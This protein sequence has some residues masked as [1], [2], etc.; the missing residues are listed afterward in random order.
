MAN[1][2]WVGGTDTWNATAGTKWATTSGGTGGA[3]VPT[4]S[5]DVFFDANS[6]SGTVTLGADG[7]CQDINFTGFTGSFEASSA[8]RINIYGSTILGSGTTYTSY[9]GSLW[10]QGNST[11]TLTTNGKQIGNTTS[12]SLVI[13]KG[14]G[15]LT[16]LDSINSNLI[17]CSFAGGT[18]DLNDFDVTVSF[19]RTTTTNTKTLNMGSGTLTFT[20]F[21]IFSTDNLTLNAETSTI[22]LLVNGPG[23]RSFDGKGLTYHNF[24][25]A[26]TS[27]ADAGSHTIIGSN[28]F[29]SLEVE[30][31]PSIIQFANGTTQ[32]VSNFVADGTSTDGIELKPQSSVSGT[33]WTISKTSGTIEV[34]HC[35]I[36]G[37]EATGGSLWIAK[38]STDDGDNT[39]WHFVEGFLQFPT[40]SYVYTGVTFALKRLYELT[41]NTGNYIYTG[42]NW[43]MKRVYPFLFSTGSY[44]Y[45]GV[46][47]LM[48]YARIFAF[49]TGSYTYSGVNWLM[50]ASRKI[51]FATGHYT[52]T[53]ISWMM[54][55]AY[56][57]A[58]GTGAY[59]YTGITWIMRKAYQI[60]FGVGTYIYKG[61]NWILEGPPWQRENKPPVGDWED[62]IKPFVTDWEDETKPASS[63]WTNDDKPEL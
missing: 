55:L 42:V 54:R 23:G 21:D 27:T 10:F 59:T 43:L 14:T 52:Y 9:N 35:T 63:G 5:D 49:T 25:C 29:N 17:T 16:L 19:F 44:T 1:R 37:S 22:K 45:T 51:A 40:G 7:N 56:N 18:F 28:T 13:L 33:Q 46:N 31:I 30:T 50:K 48:K 41:F 36:S 47:W 12:V 38:N 34:E 60:L 39:G 8:R 6:G 2:Y 11:A 58:F 3:S 57:M 61:A 15:S 24:T 20:N 26:K 4:S 62:Q 32:T 53:G